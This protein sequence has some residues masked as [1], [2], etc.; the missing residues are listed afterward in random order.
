M[1]DVTRTL[2]EKPTLQFDVTVVGAGVSGLMLTMKLAELGLKT[3]LIESKPQLA[4]GPSTTNE[5]W[6]H[7]GTYH[8]ISS[9]SRVNAMQIAKRCI[10]GHQQIRNFAPEAIEDIDIPSFALVKN[11]LNV[12]EIISRWDE[13]GVWYKPVQLN[14]LAE[15]E[16]NVRQDD[17]SVVFE[18]KDIGINTRMLYRKL[19][20]AGQKAGA[21]ILAETK[22][23]FHAPD[24]ATVEQA[25][26][27]HRLESNLFVYTAGYG[28]KQFFAAN[29]DISIPLRYW[30]SHLMIVPRLTKASVFYLDPQEAAMMNHGR[31]SIVGLNQDAFAQ[32][33]PDNQIIPEGVRAITEA[34]Q[35][36]FHTIDKDKMVPLACIKTD[37]A[38]KPADAR[39]LNISVTEPLP[40]HICVLPGK[41]TEAPYVTDVVTRM[42][43]ERIRDDTIALRPMDTI[44]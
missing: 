44:G 12:D 28:V 13:A 23:E 20:T 5:G 8:A 7:R 38:E 40:G 41:M 33:I 35:R 18:V 24:E 34:M 21:T 1:M 29:F 19:L 25:G 43:Y 2:S 22:L 39:S 9:Q 26:K 3:L 15:Y 17:V 11:Q 42:V 32:E 30:K 16:P 4:G 36:L 10:Y 37:L 6:L 31:Y 27:I 14:H